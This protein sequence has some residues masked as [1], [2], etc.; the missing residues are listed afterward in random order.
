M[1][2]FEGDDTPSRGVTPSSEQRNRTRN[3]FVSIKNRLLS[4]VAMNILI[5]R[6]SQG[7]NLDIVVPGVRTRP[8]YCFVWGAGIRVRI[9]SK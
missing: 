6:W 1:G 5:A 4:G 8:W 2:S 7:I 3:M 9:D